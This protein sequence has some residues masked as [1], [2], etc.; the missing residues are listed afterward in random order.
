MK[1]RE[2]LIVAMFMKA[3]KLNED[4]IALNMVQRYVQL[5]LRSV[6]VV[7]P[8]ILNKMQKELHK[9]DEVQL[10]LLLKL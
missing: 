8:S 5:L 7:V 9:V 10:S 3:V 1:E 4:S 6:S 2:Q